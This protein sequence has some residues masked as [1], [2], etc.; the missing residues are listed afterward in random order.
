MR[1]IAMNIVI[2]NRWIRGLAA[3]AWLCAAGLALLWALFARY[4]QLLQD[5]PAI[6]EATLALREVGVGLSVAAS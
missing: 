5:W 1:W 2:Q 4:G 6:V 3:A